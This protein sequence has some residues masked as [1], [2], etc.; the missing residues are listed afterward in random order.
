MGLFVVGSVLGAFVGDV[1]G[2]IV[3]TID[4]TSL[5]TLVGVLTQNRCLSSFSNSPPSNMLIP[6][7]IPR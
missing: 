6:S 7:K 5:G 4:G 3:G 2:D 1:V